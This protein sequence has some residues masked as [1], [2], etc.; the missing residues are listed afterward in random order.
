Y[1]A[2]DAGGRWNDDTRDRGDSG[3]SVGYGKIPNFLCEKTPE[4]RSGKQEKA[5]TTNCQWCE[6]KLEAFFSEDLGSADLELFQAHL[7]SCE[8][9]SRQVKELREIDPMVHQVLQHRLVQA[10]A[11]G[12]W[13]TRPRVWKVAL[14]GSG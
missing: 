7:A 14:A 1:A 8:E 5:M 13:N 12:Q 9:C 6:S 3:N 2:A 11:A 10:R 4:G